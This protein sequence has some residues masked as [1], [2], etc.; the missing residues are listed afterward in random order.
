MDQ[1]TIGNT[2]SSDAFHPINRSNLLGGNEDDARSDDDLE[3]RNGKSDTVIV[4]SLTSGAFADGD[5]YDEKSLNSRGSRSSVKK[6]FRL[7][8]T[9]S[10][11]SYSDDRSESSRGSYKRYS[12][13]TKLA[14][15]SNGWED[16]SDVDYEEINIFVYIGFWIRTFFVSIG[17]WLAY[18]IKGIATKPKV[19]TSFLVLFG[20]LLTCGILIVRS[21]ADDDEDELRTNAYGIANEVGVWFSAELDKTLLPLFTTAQFV[22]ELEIFHHLPNLARTAPLQDR[23]NATWNEDVPITWFRNVTET[24]DQEVFDKFDE[25]A[26]RIKKDAQMERILVN[27]QLAP[28]AIVSVFHPLNNTED[29]DD[30][31]YLDSTGAQGHDLLND[32]NRTFIAQATVPAY[33]IVTAGPLTLVQGNVPVV[34]ECL[35]AR[36]PIYDIEDKNGNLYEIT[37]DGMTYPCWGFAVI[38]INWEAFKEKSGI[39]ER[40]SRE[41]M[42]FLLTR[43]DSNY[44]AST[45]TW[46]N[47]TVTI[48]E[49]T[50]SEEL[51]EDNSVFVKLD[52]TDNEWVLHVG[53]VDGFRPNYEEWANPLV[54]VFSFLTSFLFALVLIAKEDHQTLLYKMMPPKA[55]AKLHKGETVIERY[56]MVT[57]FFSDIVGFTTMAGEM[58]PLGVMRMLN[59]LYTEFDKLVEKHDLYKVETIGDAYMV[60]GG[61]PNKCSGP[62]GAEKIALFALDAIECVKD[63]KVDDTQQIFIRVG[64]G[65]G[66]VVAGVVGTAMPRYCLFGDTVNLASRME[67]TSRKMR[68]QCSTVTHRLLRDAPSTEFIMKERRH[69]KTGEL[70]VDVKGKGRQYTYWI[71]G[72]GPRLF[73]NCAF[74][75]DIKSPPTCTTGDIDNLDG[76]DLNELALRDIYLLA[77]DN[78]EEDVN[79]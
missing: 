26:A 17:S 37:V 72:S 76:V 74:D 55:I 1:H 38:L 67:S 12:V 20:G 14:F 64:L 47:R 62:R 32:P 11:T 22:Q 58:T 2:H 48:A 49:S 45:D 41:E 77:D 35:I 18:A 46:N 30:P 7:S 4:A 70:G 8:K 65:S 16:Q 54:A 56:E 23:G 68:I 10:E 6:M 51:N 39:Y 21:Y 36:L 3:N 78:D 63:F 52:T 28:A 57:I 43:T 34:R 53:Y 59:Q 75:D 15:Q 73:R 50:Q 61:A 29:F 71:E 44:I 24:I 19:L 69:E 66:P 60:L 42:E 33:D 79:N 5:E 9:R 25:I 40:F 31:L 13:W 27:V